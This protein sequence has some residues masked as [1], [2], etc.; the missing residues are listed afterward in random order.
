M[1]NFIKNVKKHK[2]IALDCLVVLLIIAS[3]VIIVI[4]VDNGG[5]QGPPTESGSTEEKV[6]FD[7]SDYPVTVID[8]G[9]DMLISIKSIKHDDQ[10]WKIFVL[11]GEQLL[12]DNIV[13]QEDTILLQLTPTGTGYNTICFVKETKVGN[14]VCDDVR[15]EIV[16]YS[17]VVK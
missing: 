15:I 3:A 11:P 6:F 4:M 7:D 16:F 13:E 14:I 8:Q 2:L 10:K 17:R 5:T 1:K 9:K 12:T